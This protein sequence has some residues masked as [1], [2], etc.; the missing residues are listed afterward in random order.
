MPQNNLNIKEKEQENEGGWVLA[1]YEKDDSFKNLEVGEE[2]VG[3]Y[4]SQDKNYLGKIF[5]ILQEE[6]GEMR[7]MNDTTNL[8]KW[9]HNIEPGDRIK[10]VRLPDKKLPQAHSSEPRKPL[11]MYK[12]YVWKG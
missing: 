2:F 9:M 3:V 10:I 7:K 5:Y 11:Q 6:E 12:V 8:N 1:K 4:V